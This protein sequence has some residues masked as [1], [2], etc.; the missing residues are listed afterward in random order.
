MRC[1]LVLL[2]L[3]LAGCRFGGGGFQGD[4]DG[5]VFDPV[6]TVFTYVDARNELLTLRP[7]P[8]VVVVA[9]WLAFDPAADLDRVEGADLEDMRHEAALRD[10]LALVFSDEPQAGDALESVLEAGNESGDFSARVHLQPELLDDG[11]TFDSFKPFASTRT[12]GVSVLE[13]DL[14]GAGIRADVSLS[15]VRGDA[16]P[17][18]ARE[19]QVTGDL[20]APVVDERVAEHNLSVLGLDALLGLP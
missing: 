1:V 2:T 6:G 14:Q 13:A 9:T 11:S 7:D 15:L 17:G 18:D 12:V 19:G 4:L 8:R 20:I 16:D 5:Q 10:N 3:A